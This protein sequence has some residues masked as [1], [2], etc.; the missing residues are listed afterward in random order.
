M[1]RNH[2]GIECL[3]R[4]FFDTDRT[5]RAMSETRAQTI[6]EFVGDEPRLPVDDLNGA[7]GAAWH[8]LPAAVALVWIDVHDF[9]R[10][11]HGEHYDSYYG[12][13]IDVDQASPLR[14]RGS[15]CY[16]QAFS[17]RT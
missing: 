6:T 2:I 8:A 17:G 3:G 15:S 5:S 1:C 16:N 13:G 14:R 4:T 10:G 9:S 11:F 12:R 7:F